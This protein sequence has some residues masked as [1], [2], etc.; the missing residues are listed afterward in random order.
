M[1]ADVLRGISALQMYFTLL[2]YGTVGSNRPSAKAFG[3]PSA[4]VC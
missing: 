4:P 2:L 3:S 1:L